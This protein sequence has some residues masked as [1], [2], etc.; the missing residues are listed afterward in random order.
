M[1]NAVR[2]KQYAAYCMPHAS[3]NK[4]VARVRCVVI[5]LKSIYLQG[6]L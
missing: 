1:R 4:I 3:S 6:I 2:S 5:K